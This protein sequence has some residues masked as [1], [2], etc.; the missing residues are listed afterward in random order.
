MHKFSV[1]SYVCIHVYIGI[2]KWAYPGDQNS[3]N[4]A[5]HAAMPQ[6]QCVYVHICM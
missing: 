3:C 5:Q 6:L 4:S 1:E 2:G